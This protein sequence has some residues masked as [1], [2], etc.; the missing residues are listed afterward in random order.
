MRAAPG[1][2][3]ATVLFTDLVGSTE[4][5]SRLG[6]LRY[7]EV[8]R[9]HFAV[10]RQAVADVHGDEVKTMGDGIMAVFASAVDAVACAVAMQQG[11]DR[12]RRDEAELLEIRVGLALG[13]VTFEAGDV[14]GT[15]VVEAARLV[16]RARGG[17]ILTTGLLRAVVGTRSPAAFVDLGALELK[18]LPEPVPTYEVVWER[19]G[20]PSLP[21][22]P[23]LDRSHLWSFVGRDREYEALRVL[24]KEAVGGQRKVALLGGEPGVGKTRLVEELAGAVH[25]EGAVVLAGRCDED[26]A[27][28]YQPFAEALRHFADHADDASPRGLAGRLGRY[29]GDLARLVPEIAER[30]PDLP[31]ALRS[32]PDS[33]RYRLFE[34]VAG[35]VAALAEGDGPVLF[36]VDDLQWAAKPTLLM[37][38]HLIAATGTRRLLIMATYRD[39]DLRP[40]GA[41]TELL[42]DLRREEQVERFSLAGLGEEGVRDFLAAAAGHDLQASDIEVA[43]A[44]HAETAGNPFFVGEVLR[45]LRESGVILRS[46]GRWVNGVPAT[47]L[48]IPAGVREVV[49]RRL[50]RLSEASNNVLRTAAVLG[51]EFDFDVLRR[52]QGLADALD[53]EALLGAIEE[54]VAARL[55]AEVPSAKGGP[56]RFRFSHNLV[57]ETLY[58][59]LS[60][61][62]RQVI[63]GRAAL[64]SEAVHG[65]SLDA[66]LPAL[67]Y[68]FGSAGAAGDPAKA[69]DYARRAGDQAMARLAFESAAAFYDE[70]L[71]ALSV[72]PSLGGEGLRCHLLLARAGAR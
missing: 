28:P 18:G 49:E 58:D 45:H 61:A 3:T 59:G 57:R 11:V 70:A 50:R 38:R 34:A 51:V 6:D 29:G 68:H 27:V 53:Y 36:V 33:E 56:I 54:A 41:V 37:L 19:I 67:A 1:S 10:L 65:D 5:L 13:E 69:V 39:T 30:V 22:P 25:A 52:M 12:H 40:G 2:G 26:L 46:E 31:P 44:V 63:H 47:D 21:L 4:L 32:D 8:R 43:R 62:R 14:H 15:A 9:D 66:H 72:A 71:A 42:A 16:G 17:Q 35:W 20:G 60:A 55:V 24:W 64:A 48:G 7:D 23:F